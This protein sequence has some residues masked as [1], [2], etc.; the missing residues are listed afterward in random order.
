M[1]RISLS[2]LAALMIFSG[3]AAQNVD[4]ALRYSQLFYG[5]T[6]RFMSMGGAFT[7]LGGD[8]STLSQNPAGLGV[9]RASEMSFTP[10][11]NYINS[12]AGFHGT[13]SDYLYNFN[14]SQAGFVSNVVSN[15]STTGLIKL[16]FGY[17]FNKTNNLHSSTRIKG[18]NNSS[19]MADYWADLSEGTRYFDLSGPEGIAYDT[20]IIDTIT[21]SGGRSYGTV[22]SNYGDNPPSKYGQTVSRLI[23]NDGFTGEH[24]I[25]MG[26]NYSD[27]FFFGA[28]FGISQLRYNSQYQHSE[29]VNDQQVALK[30]FNYLDYYENRGTGYSFKLGAIIKPVESVRIGV[31]FHS[32]VW[33]HINEYFFESISSNFRDGNRYESSNDPLRYEYKLSTPFRALGGIAFQIKKFALLSADYEFVDYRMA[34]FSQAGDGYD[35]TDKNDALKYSLRSANNFRVGGELRFN[36]VYLRSGYGYYGKAYASGED[37]ANMDYNAIS[38]GI[39]FREKNFSLDFGYTHMSSS[40]VYYLYPLN[41][42]I[43]PARANIS[44]NQN[45]FSLTLAYKMGY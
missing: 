6:A 8:I 14:L 22:F 23:S 37:N 35:Y 32:P 40:R 36:N 33:Y 12:T 16:N 43:E 18:I 26:G 2:I 15:N 4:D 45:M 13:T 25:S 34:K 30:N 38:G 9:F 29:T 19:S 41:E 27:K 20:W 42:S 1:K 28:T 3:L 10:Q 24:A 5:G 11:L 21:G 17:S 7:A 39:G 31:A 44:D